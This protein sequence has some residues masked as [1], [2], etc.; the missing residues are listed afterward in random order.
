MVIQQSLYSHTAWVEEISLSEKRA[1]MLTPSS[2]NLPPD[3]QESEKEVSLNECYLAT[4][5][6]RMRSVS[7]ESVFE[8][9]TALRLRTIVEN[10]QLLESTMS[11]E[12]EAAEIEDVLRNKASEWFTFPES[13]ETTDHFSAVW[14]WLRTAL[15]SQQKRLEHTWQEPGVLGLKLQPLREQEGDVLHGCVVVSVDSQG[16]PENLLG[17]D[18]CEI[19]GIKINFQTYHDILSL[20]TTA[21]RPLNIKFRKLSEENEKYL[22][23]FSSPLSS[24][25]FMLPEV[26][27]PCTVKEEEATSTSTE[28]EI[29]N[30]LEKKEVSPKTEIEESVISA[31]LENERENIYHAENNKDP[32]LGWKDP[33][34]KKGGIIVTKRDGGGNVYG[35]MGRCKVLATAEQ[36][37]AAIH[38]PT[39]TAPA[40]TECLDTISDPWMAEEKVKAT[41]SNIYLEWIDPRVNMPIIAPISKRDFVVGSHSA[42]VPGVAKDP[43]GML[44]PCTLRVLSLFIIEGQEEAQGRASFEAFQN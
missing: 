8:Y 25:R 32:L 9:A 27:G 42:Y 44:F 10:I 33:E 43:K 1:E 7:S 41:R 21:K 16:L 3:Q 40:V 36:I 26:P 20:I 35:Y 6:W 34:K 22:A 2:G 23:Y 39:V 13:I 4:T 18:I 29:V 12:M 28:T 5:T 37:M 14:T 30:V 17:M 15:T 19:N 24:A 31:C 38:D 11:Q